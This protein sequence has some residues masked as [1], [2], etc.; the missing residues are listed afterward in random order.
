MINKMI[1]EL[2]NFLLIVL[3]FIFGYGV[4]TQSLMFHNQ[5]LDLSLLKNL[6]FSAYFILGG[7]YYEREKLMQGKLICKNLFKTRSLHYLSFFYVF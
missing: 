6:F 5:K 2:M 4:S 3:V 7:D 1:K